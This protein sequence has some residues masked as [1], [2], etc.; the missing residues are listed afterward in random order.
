MTGG[1]MNAFTSI[2]PN[3]FKEIANRWA[4]QFERRGGHF[5]SITLYQ[6]ESSALVEDPT[7]RW[8][9]VFD[10]THWKMQEMTPQEVIVEGMLD[11]YLF[12]VIS[13]NY[14]AWVSARRMIVEE[15]TDT[16]QKEFLK[17]SGFSSQPP[18][19]ADKVNFPEY[20][21][22]NDFQDVYTVDAPENWRHQWLF[23]P[24]FA[25]CD[26]PVQV[27][28]NEGLTLY[29]DTEKQQEDNSQKQHFQIEIHTPPGTT[30]EQIR[31]RY[32]NDS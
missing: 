25:G 23:I 17:Q 15:D 11:P 16:T 5:N 30:W 21:L 2:N 31:I 24:W 20:F 7:L 14:P 8:A 12:L 10:I 4:A 13:S 1:N 3:K 22:T 18:Y 28:V 26:L 9:I 19:V 29:S 6:Y 32:V 27:A